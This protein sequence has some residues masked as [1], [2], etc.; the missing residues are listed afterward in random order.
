MMVVETCI[1]EKYDFLLIF[2]LLAGEEPGITERG[3]LE[4]PQG[5]VHQSMRIP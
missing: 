2:F 3:R 5:Q 4:L 1:N